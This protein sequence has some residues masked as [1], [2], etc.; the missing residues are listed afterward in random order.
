[1]GIRTKHDSVACWYLLSS[2]DT[3]VSA[4]EAVDWK[5]RTEMCSYAKLKILLDEKFSEIIKIIK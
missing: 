4:I 3:V 2:T 1:V 5:L